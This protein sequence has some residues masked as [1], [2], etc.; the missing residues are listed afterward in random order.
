MRGDIV[1]RVYGVHAGRDKDVYFGA[2]RTRAAAEAEIDNLRAREMHGR[3]WAEQYHDRGFVVREVAV[4]T[5]FE[6]PSRPKARD[7]YFVKT[8]P[9]FNGPGVM[10][11]AVVEVFRRD[12]PDAVASYVRN[13]SPFQTFEPFRQGGREFALIS[14]DYTKTAVLDLASGG[15]IAEE[16]EAYY[17]ADRER[18]GAGFCPV[19]FYVPDWWDVHD[20]SIIP[21][22]EYWDGRYE[23]PDGSFGFVW[24]C[25]WG[26]DSSWK[27]QYLDLSLVRD[28]VVA[29]DER[30]GYVEMATAGYRSPCF[31][32]APCESPSAP[33]PFI[34]VGG[35]AAGAAVTF[36]VD[37]AFDLGTGRCRDWER[38]RVHGFE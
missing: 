36:A 6:I 4:E 21:G 31:D 19:G 18:P 34:R 20:G 1:Y 35:S 15:V 38:K 27:V 8:T 30:F 16:A 25:H 28:G 13:H 9:R 22:S 29:R 7:R 23:W 5:D 32:P 37:V 2:F 26:D 17:D 33:P 3:N 12:A 14:R 10:P 11:S 24:G